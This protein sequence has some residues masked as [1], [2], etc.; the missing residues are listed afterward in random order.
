[1]F[2][3]LLSLFVISSLSCSIAC[4]NV[5]KIAVVD[6]Q[7]LVNSSAQ[8]KA[9]RKERDAK[10]NEIAQL[11]KK[12]NEDVKKQTDPAK[13]KALADKYNKELST[14]QETNAKAY[15]TKLDAVDKSITTTIIQQA[16]AMGYDIVLT[17]GVV[18]YGG[19]DITDAISK[20]VK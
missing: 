9:L 11:I 10:R 14:K 8:V 12:A 2:K 7:K 1:M 20:V 19:D 6:V 4:A 15:K 3:K 5:K 13:K 18:L 16:K 17:K